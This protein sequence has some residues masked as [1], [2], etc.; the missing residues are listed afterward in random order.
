MPLAHHIGAHLL[1]ADWS[2]YSKS[3]PKEPCGLCGIRSSYGQHL[4]TPDIVEA[5][6]V[7]LEKHAGTTRAKHQCKLAGAG[8]KYSLGSAGNST[9]GAPC[10]NRPIACPV[11]RCPFSVWSYNLAAHSAAAHPTAT[12]TAEFSEAV[13]LGHHEVEWCKHLI[14][15][16]VVPTTAACK[17]PACP[18]K[19]K[20]QKH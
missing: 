1:Q 3:K 17:N 19:R 11:T 8:P 15:K 13:A 12:L 7:T 4:H 18:C 10:T 2:V 14:T 5:C 9:T 16:K 20:K 6:T